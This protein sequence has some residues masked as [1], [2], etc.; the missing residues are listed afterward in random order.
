MAGEGEVADIAHARFARAQTATG[1]P[2]TD[3]LKVAAKAV[4]E[5]PPGKRL[6][7]CIVLLA[8]Q[9]DD[10]S[11]G[12]QQITA[13]EYNH[14]GVKGLLLSGLPLCERKA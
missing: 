8:W 7:Q 11:T 2:P 6:V 5:A 9:H 13:G 3:A 10:G 14:H 1:L 4:D 12:T